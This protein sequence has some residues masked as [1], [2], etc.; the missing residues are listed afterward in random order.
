M[1]LFVTGKF[2]LLRYWQNN[3]EPSDLEKP[4]NRGMLTK[5][6]SKYVENAVISI[7]LLMLI[8][9]WW[10]HG[11]VR[12]EIWM[13][14]NSSSSKLLLLLAIHQKLSRPTGIVPIPVQYAKH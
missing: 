5:H 1:R 9:A 11:S 10:I 13:R 8:V 6:T 7:G 14:Q 12:N 4:G 3:Y 2:V